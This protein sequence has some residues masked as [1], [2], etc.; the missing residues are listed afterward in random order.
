M[1]KWYFLGF[2]VPGKSNGGKILPLSIKHM[3]LTINLFSY[4]KITFMKDKNE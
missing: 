2:S 4:V 3:E 1:Y